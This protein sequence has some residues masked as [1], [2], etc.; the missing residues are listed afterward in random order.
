M[1]IT[2]LIALGLTYFAV[3]FTGRRGFPSNPLFWLNG[4]IAYIIIYIVGEM[5]TY[6]FVIEYI[7]ENI[8][9][10]ILFLYF[11]HFWGSLLYA[12]LIMKGYELFSGFTRSRPVTAVMTGIYTGF[13]GLIFIVPSITLSP[14]PAYPRT[15]CSSNLRKIGL[16]LSMYRAEKGGRIPT[17]ETSGEIFKTLIDENY[18]ENKEW[19]SC[20]GNPVAEVDFTTPEGVSY[21]IDP[22][23]P[24]NCHSK[25]VVMADRPP[26]DLNHGDGVNVL[27]EDWHVRF[28]RPEDNGPE[29]KISNPYIE[30]DY[31]IYAA[32]G[33]PEKNAWIRWEREQDEE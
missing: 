29:D 15:Q 8:H 20:P 14:D 17:G 3:F 1:L 31:D 33:D 30:E 11:T 26:W 22:D 7:M 19:L 13:V 24:P 10:P 16:S 2:L 32:T 28:V 4:I 23:I 27:F 9:P 6:F 5:A 18:L 12:I 21:Y 25:R